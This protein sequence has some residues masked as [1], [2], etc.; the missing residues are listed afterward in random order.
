MD[1]N[2]QQ[3]PV[4]QFRKKFNVFGLISALIYLVGCFLPYIYLGS[5]VAEAFSDSYGEGIMKTFGFNSARLNFWDIG[6]VA[7]FYSGAIEPEVEIVYK[8][9]FVIAVALGI[10]TLLFVLVKTKIPVIV[11]GV[12][13]LGA[14]CFIAWMCYMITSEAEGTSISYGV[15]IMIIGA[16][17]SIIAGA[18]YRTRPAYNPA[19]GYANSYTNNGYGQ[20]SFVA[21]S[22]Q[23]QYQGQTYQAQGQTYQAQGQPYQA[24]GQTYQ[25][26]GQPYQ[27]QGQPY[28]AQGQPYQAPEQP[29]QAP[30]QPYQAPEQSQQTTP[31]EF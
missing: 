3:Q 20:Q 26:Q 6:E 19:A 13:E 1:Y 12:L 28:Q 14:A 10:L 17:L 5:D 8:A 2:Y 7:K 25:A 21:Q 4:P 31:G 15:Y 22:V 23:P 24:Q 11:F 30:E 9:I 18:V 29:Y 16:I 27:A